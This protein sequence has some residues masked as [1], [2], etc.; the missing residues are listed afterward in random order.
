MSSGWLKQKYVQGLA[1]VC[2]TLIRKCTPR[3]CVQV[4]DD[5]PLTEQGVQ[6][7]HEL[8][9]RLQVPVAYSAETTQDSSNLVTKCRVTVSTFNAGRAYMPD[10]LQSFL[11]DSSNSTASGK[12]PERECNHPHRGR[13]G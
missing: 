11:Q 7:A 2:W 5:P 4:V 1:W 8:G 10:I 3:I 12:L 13:A 9:L 6:Q